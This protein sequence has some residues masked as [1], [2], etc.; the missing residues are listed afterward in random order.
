MHD[1]IPS[2]YLAL[3]CHEL[4]RAGRLGLT[5]TVGLIKLPGSLYVHPHLIE[6]GIPVG[7]GHVF[8]HGLLEGV[9]L[10]V[11]P[12][13]DPSDLRGVRVPPVGD[14]LTRTQR[15]GTDFHFEVGSRRVG[16]ALVSQLVADHLSCAG[17]GSLGS[18]QQLATDSA[19]RTEQRLG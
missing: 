14:D 12:A 10:V 15:R 6:D 18:L 8:K 17:T 3:E 2:V 13:A 5:T 7:I 9:M 11:P 1:T 4:R 19:G 16:L